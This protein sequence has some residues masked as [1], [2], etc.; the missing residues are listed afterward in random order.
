[1]KDIVARL[2]TEDIVLAM[3]KYKSNQEKLTT[4]NYFLI[5]TEKFPIMNIVKN[6]MEINGS[7]ERFDYDNIS[8]CKEILKNKLNLSESRFLNDTRKN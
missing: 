5:H 2:K 8:L 4:K 3:L 6:A 7:F 1:M